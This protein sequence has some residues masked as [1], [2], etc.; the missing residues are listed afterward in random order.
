MVG[1]NLACASAASYGNARFA[2]EQIVAAFGVGLATGTQAAS[3]VPL[4]TSLAGTTVRVRDSVGTERLAPLFFVS[5][6]QINYQIPVGTANGNAAITVT[7]GDGSLSGA[8]LPVQT[9]APGLFSA[10]AN[11]QGVPAAVL[12]RVKANGAQ[13]F[14]PVAQFNASTGQFVAVPI[15]LGPATDQVFLILFGTGLR[16]RTSLANVIA[17]IGGTGAQTLFAGA[18]GSLVGLDQV[19]L[20]IPRNLLGRGDVDVALTVDG[21]VV[22]PMRINI[23]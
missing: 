13:S 14:E 12:L 9:V 2:S 21:V 19:N 10:N 17:T 22:N 5:A 18:Q 15:D 23:K 20:G 1:K 11:G 8:A 3:S 16:N 6:G 7:A 4:P